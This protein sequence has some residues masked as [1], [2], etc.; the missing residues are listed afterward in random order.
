MKHLT[1]G[2]K[3]R[4]LKGSKAKDAASMFLE[5]WRK[6]GKTQMT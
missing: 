6:L 1:K 3:S 2:F 4:G 5:E